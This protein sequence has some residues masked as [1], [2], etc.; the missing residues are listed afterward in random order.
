MVNK[1]YLLAALILILIISGGIYAYTYTTATGTI[2]TPTPAGDLATANAT[3]S[4]PNWN[5]VLWTVNDD[6]ILRPDAVGDETAIKDQYPDSGA[7]WDKVDEATADDDS[8]YVYTPSLGW[9]ED[10]YNIPNH[11][12]QT[13]GGD[14]NYVEVFMTSR[15]SANATQPSAY[16]NIKT[17]G[18][19]DPGLS[20]NLTTSYAEY[21][22]AW[23]DNP[24]SGSSWTWTEI[25]S[26][27]IGLGM[28]EGDVGV[29][30]LC[31]QV[32]ADI[33]FDAP[34]LNGNTPT[35][36][37]FEITVD[38]DYSG[39][40]QVRVY[41]TNTADLLKAYNYLDM[42]LYL[43]SSEEA[44][45]TPDY[46]LMDLQNGLATFNLVGISGGSYTLSVTGGTYQLVSREISEWEAEWTVTPELYCEV[47]QR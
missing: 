44:G 30:S 19:E 5:S 41:L 7:H 15:A 11:S 20:E 42:Y 9:E 22:N 29:N 16:V 34:E 36:D 32:Y 13:A 10:L 39:N 45:E 3:A 37:L 40:L 43:E 31:T 2:G 8:T 25:D 27:Q 26:L 18:F 38:D 6:L 1:S 28:R 33:N 4:Q 47:E 14:I 24:V 12:T 23:S 21:S 46:Q 35:G 17:Y